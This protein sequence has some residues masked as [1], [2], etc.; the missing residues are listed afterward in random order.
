[1]AAGSERG[2]HQVVDANLRRRRLRGDVFDFAIGNHARKAVRAQDQ[3]VALFDV[4]GKVVGIHGGVRTQRTRDNR[5]VGMD[6]RLVGCNFA[7]VHELLHIGVV[8]GHADERALVEQI[9]ARVAHVG[10]G[11][12]VVFDIGAGCR[13]AHTGLAQA[14]ECG[15]DDGGV[16]SF[17]GCG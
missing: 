8:A 4:Q 1:M 16:G 2:V 3:A 12:H 9:G 17:D 6:A 11:E 15:L 5:A 13:A 10:D 7:S 14:V